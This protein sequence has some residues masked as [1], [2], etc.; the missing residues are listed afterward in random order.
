MIQVFKILKGFDDIPIDSYFQTLESPTRG[1]SMKLFKLSCLKSV[2]QNSFAIGV[3]EIW[4]SL[5][6]GI[7]SSQSV[8]QFKTKLDKYWASKRFDGPE[9]Y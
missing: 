5:P 8:L 2:R 6:E 9:I 1:H 7:L 4:N 3:T